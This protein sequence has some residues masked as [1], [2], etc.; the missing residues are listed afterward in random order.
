MD[1][2]AAARPKLCSYLHLPVQSGSTDVLRAMRRG[3]H[4]EAYLAKIAGLRERIPELSFGTDIIVGF[5]TETEADFQQTLSLIEEV[6]FDTVY[7][8]AYSVR[9][10][11]AALTLGPDL[12]EDVKFERLARLNDIQKDIQ[13][14]RNLSFIGRDVDVLVE[15]PNR[16][17][18]GEWTGR[19]SEAR[20]V[21]FPGESA[22]GRIEKVRVAQVSAFS[23]R[24]EIV[25]GA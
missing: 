2:M 11:T 9:P 7:S 25:V 13:A 17:N 6:G 22:P 8:F 3:Y 12:P 4:R 5:P 23:L 10:G 24:G 21:H 16:R 1:A 15:G 20:W 14:R 18:A 19:T